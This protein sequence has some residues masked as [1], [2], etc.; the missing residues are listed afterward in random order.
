MNATLNPFLDHKHC[1]DL[2]GDAS[3]LKQRTSA[4]GAAKIVGATVAEVISGFIHARPSGVLD[5][6]CGRGGT[7]AHLARVS[8]PEQL[9][10][11]DAS[12]PLLNQARQRVIEHAP[13]F[14]G[15]AQFICGDFHYIPA[16][17]ETFDIIVAAFCLYH[18]HAPGEVVA[19][20]RRCL[21]RGGKIILVT[22]SADSYATLDE[23]V[24]TSGLDPQATRRPCLYESFHSG[25]AESITAQYIRV[26]TVVHHRHR[27]HFTDAT[28]A[29][30]Y[31]ATNPKYHLPSQRPD[32]LTCWLDGAIREHGLVTES[33]VTYVVASKT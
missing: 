2:Y 19:E 14:T 28:H 5:V 30:R 11:L 15:R 20:L 17:D 32:S 22:K 31:I 23:L 3:R 1:Q 18:A 16:S 29:A 33:T 10:A 8:E 7:T 13:D 4:L 24:V 25:N 6:G 27:F 12:Q 9:M 26:D 21:R